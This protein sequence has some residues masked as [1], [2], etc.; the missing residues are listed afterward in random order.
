MVRYRLNTPDV[1]HETVDGEALII[2]TPSGAYFSLQETG[3]QLWNAL[4]AGHSS[5]EISAAYAESVDFTSTELIA[6]VELFVDRLLG[7]Q[8]LVPSDE[9]PRSGILPPAPQP[10][11]VPTIQKFTDMQ[12]LLLVD[13]IHEVDPQAGWPH[14]RDAP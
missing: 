12:E 5:A 1:I 3:E 11:S 4:L 6:A 8:L 14:R 7:E 10:F 9:Q 2:H 13:P